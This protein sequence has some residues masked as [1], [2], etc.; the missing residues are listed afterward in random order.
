M[1]TRTK[2][3]IGCILSIILG[4]ILIATGVAIIP[5]IVLTVAGSFLTVAGIGQLEDENG[6]KK[7]IPMEDRQR[8]E[9]KT[10]QKTREKK[11]PA[12]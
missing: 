10:S 11:P 7:I 8:S 9:I 6:L 3:F 4:V 5:G 1:E 12:S 2:F